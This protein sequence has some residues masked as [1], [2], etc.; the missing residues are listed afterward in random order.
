MDCTIAVESV[1]EIKQRLF[2][3]TWHRLVVTNSA[4][5]TPARQCQVS[6]FG[7]KIGGTRVTS[8]FPKECL[9]Y[10]CEKIS[11]NWLQLTW[12]VVTP[13]L[14]YYRDLFQNDFL[15]TVTVHQGLTQV[16]LE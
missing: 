15:C 7:Q 9:P 5:P 16:T 11:F 1:N 10:H 6:I 14:V 8:H 4:R 3:G 2:F 13:Q 12:G